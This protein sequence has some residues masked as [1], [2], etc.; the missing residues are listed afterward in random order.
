MTFKKKGVGLIELLAVL[1]ILAILL[2]LLLPAIQMVRATAQRTSCS[3]KMRQLSLAVLN[4][5][6]AHNYL[7]PAELNGHSF[8]SQV[9]PFVEQANVFNNVNFDFFENDSRN[10]SNRKFDISVFICPSDG[11]SSSITTGFRPTNYVGNY[12]TGFQKYGDNGAFA[13]TLPKVELGSVT[14]G[15]S[16]TALISESLIGLMNSNDPR[17]RVY[18]GPHLQL[19]DQLDAFA[20][21]CRRIEDFET[22]YDDLSRCSVWTNGSHIYTLYNHVIEPNYASCTNNGDLLLGAFTASSGHTGGVNLA[23]LDGSISFVS[24]AIE[25]NVW[26]AIGSRNSQ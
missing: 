2:A 21:V 6:S 22:T 5:E 1:A 18:R 10:I 19:P 7:P 8:L 12:G 4:W 3:N 23:K 17:R 20:D 9:L 11:A 24:D 13:T 26:R 25:P 15:T 16:N 14:D